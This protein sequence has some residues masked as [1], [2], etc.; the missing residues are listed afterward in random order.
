MKL[1]TKKKKRRNKRI[2]APGYI[3]EKI[4]KNV[5]MENSCNENV[6]KVKKVD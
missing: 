5:R 3:L 2:Q 1:D 4:K 6:N